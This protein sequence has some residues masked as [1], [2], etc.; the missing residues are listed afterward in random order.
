MPQPD[1][2]SVVDG[3]ADNLF[4]LAANL[5]SRANKGEAFPK[6]EILALAGRLQDY[7]ADLQT[8]ASQMPKKA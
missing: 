7:G 5:E 1:P 3:I 4:H 8:A 2:R 6:D